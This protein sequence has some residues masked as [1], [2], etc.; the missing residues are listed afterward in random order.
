MWQAESSLQYHHCHE[1]IGFGNIVFKSPIEAKSKGPAADCWFDG[2]GGIAA[3]AAS[4]AGAWVG[5]CY[6]IFSAEFNSFSF[7]S[8]HGKS[9]FLTWARSGSGCFLMAADSLTLNLCTASAISS[10]FCVPTLVNRRYSHKYEFLHLR[11]SW[12]VT[13]ACGC[14]YWSNISRGSFAVDGTILN[15]FTNFARA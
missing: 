15:W 8:G 12:S 7:G 13:D 10:Y 9:H 3:V 4:C 14:V 1:L 6:W 11:F 5:A 2:G